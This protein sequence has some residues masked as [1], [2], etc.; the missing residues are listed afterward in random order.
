MSSFQSSVLL[1][2]LLPIFFSCIYH[3]LLPKFPPFLFPLRSLLFCYSHLPSS[4]YLCI[5][6]PPQENLT[7]PI[8]LTRLLGLCYCP[9]YCLPTPITWQWPCFTSLISVITTSY[10]FSWRFG[11]RSLW[12]ENIQCLSFCVWL[13]S[14]NLIFSSAIYSPTKFMISFLIT[15]KWYS[16]VYTFSLSIESCRTFRFYVLAIVNRTMHMAEQVCVENNMKS[17]GHMP[18]N[19]IAGS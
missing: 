11:A 13:T 1:F 3:P 10:V 9:L 2:Y 14:F 18:V 5:Y 19:D 6:S 12:K 4:H 15:D 7:T 8:S 17:L 16:I